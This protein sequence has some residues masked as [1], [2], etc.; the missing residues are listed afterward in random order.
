MSL[1]SKG[2]VCKLV[3]QAIS[4]DL[5]RA[6]LQQY[7]AIA[8]TFPIR[9]LQKSSAPFYCHYMAFRLGALHDE[10]LF[11]RIDSLLEMAENF[12]GWSHEISA[13]SDGEYAT[14]WSLLWQLQV[15]EYFHNQG[16]TVTWSGSG[17]DLCVKIDEEKLFVECYVYQKAFRH[18]SF[19]RDLLCTIDHRLRIDYDLCLPLS[20]SEDELDQLVEPLTQPETVDELRNIAAVEYPVVVS[21]SDNGQVTIYLDGEDSDS[22]RPGKSHGVGDPSEYLKVAFREMTNAKNGQNNQ[23]CNR[24]PNKVFVNALLS[25]DFQLASSIR[26]WPSA[27]EISI[28][29]GIDAVVI[30]VVG[31]SDTLTNDK[32]IFSGGKVIP[33]NSFRVV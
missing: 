15:A 18:V 1:Y 2:A 9:L 20:V 10:S 31:I 12:E 32:L 25:E 11:Q 13:M 28:P 14:F 22:Y 19:I 5:I 4:W 21:K 6:R 29:D 24:R 30:A 16:A 3:Q 27:N 26:E 33:P 8:R 7:P 23:L 17:P